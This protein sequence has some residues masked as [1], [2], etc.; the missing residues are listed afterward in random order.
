MAAAKAIIERAIGKVSSSAP[1]VPPAR[2][3]YI[4]RF[5]Q[6]CEQE[7]RPSSVAEVAKLI[8]VKREPLERSVYM[9][10]RKKNP[11]LKKVGPGKYWLVGRE[12]PK[13]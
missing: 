7:G 10:F 11:R 3:A 6:A 4:S 5:V 8:R 13:G 9:E 2:K 1:E 12:L